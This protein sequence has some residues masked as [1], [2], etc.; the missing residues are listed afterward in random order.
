[1]A[2]GAAP[3]RETP[4]VKTPD[5]KAYSGSRDAREID[6]FLWQ[7]EQDFEAIGLE[8]EK[9]K[10]RAATMYLTDTAMLWWRRRHADIERGTC[11]IDTW[12]D[13]K[14]EIQNLFYPS[15]L[16]RKNLK[17]LK[18]TG[19]LR[20]YV[21]ALFRALMLEIPDM[22]EKDLF[23]NFM[24]GL[25]NWA[26]LE[27]QRRG[28]QDLA[29]AMAVA[30]QLVEFKKTESSKSGHSKGGER[31]GTATRRNHTSHLRVRMARRRKEVARASRGSPSS[32]ESLSASFVE[33]SIY[34]GTAQ[35]GRLSMP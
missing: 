26:E 25:Q 34:H 31:R 2:N 8:E 22:P 16:A 3:M 11:T 24:D 10:V 12:D 15:N 19:S 27:L 30:E 18:H 17:R 14:R 13:F 20:D 21:K 6:N 7:M 32:L 28:A 4:R 35:R 9:A 29:T 1:M 5:P 33:A 23:F